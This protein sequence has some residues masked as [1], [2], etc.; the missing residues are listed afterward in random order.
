MTPIRPSPSGTSPDIGAYE[1]NE[2][3][4]DYNPHKYVATNG[5]NGNSGVLTDPFL[6]IQ[7]AIDQAQDDDIIHVAAGTYVE[8]IDYS[9]KNISIIGADRETTIIDG[10]ESGRVFRYYSSG[11]DQGFMISGFTIKN[12]LYEDG[13]G[14]IINNSQITLE[15]LIIKDNYATH[16]SGGINVSGGNPIIKNCIVK[17]NNAGWAMGGIGFHQTNAKV[18]NTL[19]TNNG[20]CYGSAF[21]SWSGSN[22]EFD[23]VSVVNNTG[24]WPIAAEGN[25]NISLLNSNVWSNGNNQI[26]LGGSGDPT[27]PDTLIVS[28]SN[29]ENG[30]DSTV[31][32]FNGPSYGDVIS[33]DGNINIDPMFVDSANGNYHLLSSSMLI[34]AGHPDSTDSDGSRA[35]MGAYPY[36]NT[37]SGPTWYVQT[38]GSDTDG[39]G[40]TDSPFASIQSAINFATTDGDSVT[41]AAGTYVENINFRGRNIKVVGE[42][43]ETTIIDGNQNGSVVVFESG[44]SN[45]TLISGF[46]I[47]NGT[48]YSPDPGGPGGYLRGGGIFGD[49]CSPTLR[50]LLITGNTALGSSGEGGGINFRTGSPY[51]DNLVITGN[52]ATEAGG[53]AIQGMNTATLINSQ[54][55]NNQC[56]GGQSAGISLGWGEITLK[57]VLISDNFVLQGNS[58]V[59]GGLA[60]NSGTA[61]LIN[62]TISGNIGG[63]G[64][65][66]EGAANLNITNSIIFGNSGSEIVFRPAGGA[67][68]QSYATINYSNIESGLDSIVTNDNGTVT[69]GSGNIDADPA[70]VDTANGD[71][72]LS[73]LSPV[74]SAGTDSIEIT[75][76]WYY[77]PT[78]DIEG[79]PRPNPA[80]TSP[81]MGAYESDKGVDPN[82]A[83]P[84]WYVDG[85]AGLPYGNGGP[86]APF[87]TIQAGIDASSAGGTVSVKAGTYVENI[88]YNGKNI[89]VIGENRE[90]TIIDGNQNGSVVNI[91]NNETNAFLSG[92][93]ITNGTAAYGGGIN[94][95]GTDATITNVIVEN[96]LATSHGGG[97]VS[98]GGGSILNISDSYIRNNICNNCGGG[99]ASVNN[100]GATLNLSN[101]IINNNTG[102]VGGGVFCEGGA[103]LSLNIGEISNNTSSSGGGGIYYGNTA[104]STLKHVTIS[105]NVDNIGG[106]GL[107]LGQSSSVIMENSNVLTNLPNNIY[108]YESEPS[109]SNEIII[110]YS[111]IQGGQDSIVTNNNGTVTW[112]DGNIDVDPMFV[113]TANGNYHLLASSQLINAGHPDSTDSD[114]SRADMGAYPYLNNYSG[115]NGWHVSN[116]GSDETGDG[117]GGAPFA[118]IQAGINFAEDGDSVTV[119]VG[120]YVENINFRGRNIKVVGQDRET[121]IIDGNQS[122]SVVIF[123]NGE[124]NL[125][126]LSGFTITNGNALEAGGVLC[127]T[128]SSPT[129][130]N[131]IISN[132]HAPNGGGGIALKDNSNA[133]IRNA[134]IGNNTCSG[135]GGGIYTLTSDPVLSN[136]IVE[137]NTST[138]SGGGIYAENSSFTL[139]G[140][141]VSNNTSTGD[142]PHGLK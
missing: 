46:T 136:V 16:N 17:N 139:D 142:D 32:I 125:A 99:G 104:S 62:S 87:T 71:Y 89:A 80:G 81:D 3:A 54:I 61:N 79:N 25:S 28:Y 9:G 90:T 93:T 105:D 101:V 34:N 31:Y 7:Y 120:T 123:E 24:S 40:S 63:K 2:S 111:N 116:N 129:L 68:P 1:S 64:V 133:I 30:L 38:D 51:F 134:I 96:N 83:G 13:A 74:I 5:N 75:G 26:A 57:N 39:T 115:D 41:V 49:N 44:E 50:N 45:L 58:T 140:V 73:D 20:P 128:Y 132:N 8:N 135:N 22:I 98:Y 66:I 109:D 76:T 65:F 11:N 121:T 92:F 59:S 33:S 52:H 42:D 114:G 47:T 112:G 23:N 72:H 48:G 78:T 95:T 36:L 127:V 141:T 18:I 19:F 138:G 85:S 103:F 12:G 117:D 70:F 108:F 21:A 29:I 97:V 67:S 119:M 100:G 137:N 106:G 86:G 113:D 6:T 126:L 110:S 88:N 131:L 77:A 122:G 60:I 91:A 107:F 55:I 35:D 118:S 53:A 43:R 4:A 69:W 124:S 56:D 14:M 10:N 102:N 130:E 94:C 27:N 82:Y 15:N 84:V 37:Y